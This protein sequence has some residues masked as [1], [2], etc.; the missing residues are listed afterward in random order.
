MRNRN[1]PQNGLRT[2]VIGTA[3]AAV[4]VILTVTLCIFSCTK[5]NVANSA[6]PIITVSNKASL[7]TATAQTLP[8]GRA[9]FTSAISHFQTSTSQSCWVRI[10][11]YTFNAAAGTVSVTLW[12]WKSTTEF[13]KT[14]IT[15]HTCSIDGPAKTCAQY[16]PTGWIVGTSTNPS[17]VFNGNYTY[18]TT[19][20]AL[21]IDYPLVGSGASEDWTV[22]DLPGKAVSTLTFVGSSSSY[23]ITDGF[24]FGSSMPFTGT[25]G[26]NY[27]I[28]ND[29][30]R[31][32]MTGHKRY[33]S[34]DGSAGSYTIGGSP[35]NLP[36][37]TMNGVTGGNAIHMLL[38]QSLIACGGTARVGCA[39]PSNGKTGLIH[40]LTSLN[41]SRMMVYNHHC[42]CLPNIVDYPCYNGTIHPYA[43]MQII[44]DNGVMQGLVGIHEQDQPGSVGFDY[45][46][47]E[48]LFP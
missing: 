24:G 25:A 21:H 10:C 4:A 33:C 14:L 19:T 3:I 11:N 23:G 36:F 48:W 6:P 26:V 28:V 22:S 5:R 18:D 27:K 38:S 42:A 31:V 13:G 12:Q 35:I 41:N 7:N 39:V 45:S 8:G 46:I 44:D 20:G 17:F 40:H 47:H 32:D 34:W 2:R 37:S 1:N 29:V 15:S 30:P 16:S 43:M 9:Y